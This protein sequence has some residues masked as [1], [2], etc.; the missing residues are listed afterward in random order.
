MIKIGTLDGYF[1]TSDLLRPHEK[2]IKYWLYPEKTKQ[3]NQ[4]LDRILKRLE[5]RDYFLDQM[6]ERLKKNIE[7]HEKRI[8]TS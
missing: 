8:Y 2:T 1:G 7:N 3:R 5:V 4:E 6:S